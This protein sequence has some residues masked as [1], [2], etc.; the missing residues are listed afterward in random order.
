MN[1]DNQLKDIYIR[2]INYFSCDPKRVGHFLKVHSFAKLIAENEN[3]DDD[4]LFIIQAAA[5]VHDIGIK[6]AEALFGR[7][8]GKMQEKYGPEEAAKILRACGVEENKIERICYIV[9]HHHTY[10]K[11][12]GIDYQ[13]LV[14][15]D[16]LV[17]FYEDSCDKQ[18]I[19]L[20]CKKLFKTPTAITLCQTIFGV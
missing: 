19:A 5:Y 8:D 2:M 4:T 17:N 18:T 7:N 6:R 1:T 14:E 13:I 20:T 11:I 16:F 9:G 15:A 12:D 3:V 10:D